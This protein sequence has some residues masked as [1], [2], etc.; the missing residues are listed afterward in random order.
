MEISKKSPKKLPNLVNT[1]ELDVNES[2]IRQDFDIFEFRMIKSDDS[3]KYISFPFKKLEKVKKH[4]V[5]DQHFSVFLMVAKGETTLEDLQKL[6]IADYELSSIEVDSFTDHPAGL[7]NLFL[8]LYSSEILPKTNITKNT[9]CIYGEFFYP[10]V[11]GNDSYGNRYVLKVKYYKGLNMTVQSF[12]KSTDSRGFQYFLDNNSPVPSRIYNSKDKL[13]NCWVKGGKNGEKHSVTFL[14]L[15]SYEEYKNS[16]I[17]S[18]Y[19]IL[20]DFN[21]NMGK[22]IK[23][24]LNEMPEY[25]ENVYQLFSNK[26][27]FL[28]SAINYF[29]GCSINVVDYMNEDISEQFIDSFTRML[30]KEIKHLDIQKNQSLKTG[31][32]ISITKNAKYY[33][34]G[35]LK[36]PYKKSLKNAVVQNI[37]EDNL[38]INGDVDLVRNPICLKI[39]QELMVKDSIE[40]GTVDSNFISKEKINELYKFVT[41]HDNYIDKKHNYYAVTSQYNK[42]GEIV[43]DIEK[44]D[45][46]FNK[47]SELVTALAD[48]GIEEENKG[49]VECIFYDDVKNP[50]VILNIGIYELPR[51]ERVSKRLEQSNGIKKIK[52]ERIVEDLELFRNKHVEYEDDESLKTI[53]NCLGE[54]STEK[55]S[56]SEYRQLLK[57]CGITGQK[58]IGKAYTEF[59]IDMNS[60]Y[61]PFSNHKG[62]EFKDDYAPLYW[63][64]FFRSIPGIDNKIYSRGV[65]VSVNREFYSVAEKDKSIKQTYEKGYPIR[66]IRN[67]GF[68][69]SEDY[70][71]LLSEMFDVDFVRINEATVVPFPVKFNR[72]YFNMVKDTL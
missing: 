12:K 72:E 49:S 27:T 30:N 7:I 26:Q 16:K 38:K 5:T 59:L 4:I 58:K 8:N 65:K 25:D 50:N 18:M 14:S 43:F 42:L 61:I 29:D 56:L 64:H 15:S 19:T 45:D 3:K 71:K 70:N 32:N 13:D 57:Q 22:Y 36:D 53:I 55:V 9:S 67:K 35:D 21:K 69:F 1:I 33:L 54:E 44:A 62:K 2:K 46:F 28:E 63:N 40:R 68:R 60:D 48:L 24:Q 41:F 34:K 17:G 37:T 31:I 51:M 39:L 20:N 11:N 23:F 47:D 66:E 10:V 6:Q 52:V